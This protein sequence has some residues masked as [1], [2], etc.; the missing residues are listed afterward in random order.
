MFSLEILKNKVEK[1]GAIIAAPKS[2]LVIH[3]KP[4]NDGTPYVDINNHECFY[5]SS[6][7]GHEYFRENISDLNEL[8]YL[9]FDRIVF[10]MAVDYELEN[11]IEKQDCRRLIFDKEIELMGKIDAEWQQRKQK[12]ISTILAEYPFDNLALKNHPE[13]IKDADD[14]Q[15]T[16]S[17]YWENYFKR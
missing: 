3:T 4:V 11:R 10:R 13:N 12:E 5:A 2:L 6:E 7:K 1:I 15:K 8:L 17:T 14:S 9:I 16:V